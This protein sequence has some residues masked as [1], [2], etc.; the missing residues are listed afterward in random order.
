MLVVVLGV[1]LFALCVDLLDG[2]LARQLATNRDMTSID[3]QVLAF[4]RS[5]AYGDVRSMFVRA[6]SERVVGLLFG[7]N[8]D[9]RVEVHLDVDGLVRLQS[10]FETD[11][12]FFPQTLQCLARNILQSR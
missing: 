3:N 1:L 7:H 6:V 4:R 10:I 11:S 9:R 12:G 5:D 2:L 8:D